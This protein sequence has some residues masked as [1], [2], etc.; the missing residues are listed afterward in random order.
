MRMEKIKIYQV[1]LE[2]NKF[3]IKGKLPNSL[4]KELYNGICQ[5]CKKEFDISQLQLDHIIP[6]KIGGH[7][8]NKDNLQL[9][10]NKCHH[11]KTANDIVTIHILEKIGFFDKNQFYE[12][13]KIV[14]ENFIIIKKYLINNRKR[15]AI[16]YYG[17]R[18][19]DYEQIFYDLNRKEVKDGDK[20]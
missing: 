18:G 13:P 9:L 7:F 16:W 17:T 3:E 14:I 15:K 12:D 11:N 5:E 8:F 1:S 2:R 4:K 10:C 6:V 19:I 20:T